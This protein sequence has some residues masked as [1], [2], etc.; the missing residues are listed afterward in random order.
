MH[1]GTKMITLNSRAWHGDT[2]LTLDFPERWDVS[3][4]GAQL[5]PAMTH[6]TVRDAL[7]RPIGAPPLRELATGKKRAA[8][9]RRHSKACV[10]VALYRCA[11]L[12]LPN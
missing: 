8:L 7:M 4:L 6:A 10:T 2:P 3:V 5:G 11:P 12:L 9:E 1:I